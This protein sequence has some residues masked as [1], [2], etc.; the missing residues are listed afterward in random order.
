M[1]SF[2]VLG[3]SLV[4]SLVLVKLIDVTMGLR[5]SHDDE[6]AGLDLSQHAETAYTFDDLGSMG[7]IS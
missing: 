5:V 7:R 2:A 6:L 4:V 1:A 3:F